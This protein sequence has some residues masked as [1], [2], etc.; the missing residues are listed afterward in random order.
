MSSPDDP[1]TPEHLVKIIDPIVSSDKGRFAR[2]R[3]TEAGK[4][5][6]QDLILIKLYIT[7][8]SIGICHVNIVMDK[9][10]N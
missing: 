6:Y 5:C 9:Q 8:I 4:P 7:V 10:T 1:V 2:Q 3:E